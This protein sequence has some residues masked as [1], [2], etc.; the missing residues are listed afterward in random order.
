MERSLRIQST[1]K[2]KSN[3]PAAH[4]LIAISSICQTALRLGD[5]LDHRI[6][7]EPGLLGEVNAFGEPLHETGDA[8]LVDHLVSWPAPAGPSSLHMRAR[9]RSPSRRAA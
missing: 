5:G 6:D 7:V 8:D 2:P 3:L 9:R 1:A 4:G